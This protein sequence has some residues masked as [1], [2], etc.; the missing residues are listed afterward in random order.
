[1]RLRKI[2]RGL[3]VLA[4]TVVMPG[5]LCASASSQT[6]APRTVLTIHWGAESFPGTGRIDA[7]IRKILLAR[8]D[9]PVNYFAEYLESEEFPAE[10]AS[11][12]LRDYI[13]RKFEGRHIDVV[14]AV[15]SPA[16]Q[17]ALD[18]R[19]EL[20]P[21]APIVFLV[22]VPQSVADR[23][24]TGVTGVLNDVPFGETL[25]LALNLHPSAKRVF[26]VAQAPSV[27]GYDERMR[28]ALSRV[29]SRVELIYIKEQTVPELLAAVKAIPPQSLILYT[30]YAPSEAT[31]NLYPDEIA[32]LIAEASP[33]PIYTIDEVYLGS[34]VVGGMMRVAETSGARVGQIARQILDGTP[35]EKIPIA[36]VP[37]TPI[38]DWRQVKRWGIDQAKL[39]A[40]SRIL[41]RTPTA[42]ETDRWYIIS[43]M[44]V[45]GAQLLLITG[46]LTQRERRRRAEET[47]RD[48]EASLR[49]SYERI[50]LL[51]GR[52]INA[53]ETARARISQDLHDDICQRLAMV[54]TAIDRL[55]SSS[56]DIQDTDTQQFFDALARD[57]RATFETVR[58]LSHDLHPATLR[59]L[60]LAPAI[61]AHCTE[62][63]TRHKVQVT[64]STEGDL[65][66]VPDD[67]AVCFFRIAQESLR[68]GVE[69]GR[70][71]RLAVSLTRS[72]DSIEMTVTDDGRGFT[73]E[74]ARRD[75]GGVGVITMEER[76]RV[77][78]GS[79]NILT[80]S[81]RGTTICI[82]A[83][84]KTPRPVSASDSGVPAETAPAGDPRFA[85]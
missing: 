13:R 64:F 12:T 5:M 60:G 38:F 22:T 85:S 25:Q 7:A 36:G 66:Y 17:F 35:P 50:R 79:L 16:L 78:G 21:G 32:R 59:V 67:V 19:A 74:A 24:A 11:V 62:V 68:N 83:P 43:A 81:P 53:Q 44:I 61:K 57:T 82:R 73:L 51:A 37:T 69:H 54:S 27:E 23:A 42:W 48:R 55:R 26:V 4:V 10:T 84:L 40:G 28:S 49:T 8:T 34:G 29:S 71:H 76:A 58:R 45:I 1:M 77:I 46:L 52:L 39:P 31:L 47:I 14:I 2:S 30:R 20:F 18:Y 15:A 65:Q 80:G 41:F 70:A 9:E 33:V 63:A 3:I 56:G 72:G 6:H 75:G